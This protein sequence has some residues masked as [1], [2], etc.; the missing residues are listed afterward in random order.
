MPVITLI[1]CYFWKQWD[2][3]KQRQQIAIHCGEISVRFNVDVICFV[4]F[5]MRFHNDAK[6]TQQKAS[7]N[8]TM[9]SICHWIA[10]TLLAIQQRISHSIRSC[11]MD[12]CFIYIISVATTPPSPSTLQFSHSLK[13]QCQCGFILCCNWNLRKLM[14]MLRVDKIE[15]SI[16]RLT[17]HPI[18]SLRT[19]WASHAK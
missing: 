10:V 1:L 14:E 9:D 4:L 2:I 7:W 3:Q 16:K 12:L 5:W 19:L 15:K 11:N 17:C 13:I 6:C 8:A 18:G